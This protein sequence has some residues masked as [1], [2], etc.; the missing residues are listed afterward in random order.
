MIMLGLYYTV[1]ST[2][3]ETFVE[4]KTPRKQTEEKTQITVVKIT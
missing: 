2:N 3:C 4:N 1:N